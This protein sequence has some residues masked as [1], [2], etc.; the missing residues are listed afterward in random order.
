[1]KGDIPEEVKRFLGDYISSVSQLET[2]LL[3]H[4]KPEREW[5]VVAADRELRIGEHLVEKHLAELHQREL[6]T[7]STPQPFL[8]RYGPSS[9]EVDQAV[10]SLAVIYR[11]R[12]VSLIGFMFSPLFRSLKTSNSAPNAT[13]NK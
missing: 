1:M 10:R 13:R 2:L 6:L 9:A 8:Y 7:A 12:R 4:E 11:E 3:L 5:S